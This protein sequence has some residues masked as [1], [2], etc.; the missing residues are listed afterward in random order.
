MYKD[1]PNEP[2]LSS[3]MQSG[4]YIIYLQVAIRYF[5]S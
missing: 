2:K 5:Y 1:S 4:S 3:V